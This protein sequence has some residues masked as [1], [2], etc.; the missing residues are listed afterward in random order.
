MA[1]VADTKYPYQL[2]VSTDKCLKTASTV[3]KDENNTPGWVTIGNSNLL[4]SSGG[5]GGGAVPR[6]SPFA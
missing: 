4:G 2:D 1:W 3:T 6:V 5:G